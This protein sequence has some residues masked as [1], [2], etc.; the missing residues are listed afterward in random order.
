M[1]HEKVMHI[2]GACSF[3]PNVLL[4]LK[5]LIILYTV[6]L[7]LLKPSLCLVSYN[8]FSS[9]VVCMCACA[10]VRACVCVCVSVCLCGVCVVCPQGH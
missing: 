9:H 10:C 8:S 1:Y 6:T 4:T 7:Q 5:S 2:I 3:D